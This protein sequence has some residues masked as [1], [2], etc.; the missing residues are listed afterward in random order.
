MIKLVDIGKGISVPFWGEGVGDIKAFASLAVRSYDLD[1]VETDNAENL[2]RFSSV[3]LPRDEK[4]KSHMDALQ[5]LILRDEIAR[6]KKLMS[7][8][9]KDLP[10][11]FLADLPK[12]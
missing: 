7:D 10:F 3:L 1:N 4:Y 12:E 5:Y 9:E 2:K 8:I 11:E 6:R